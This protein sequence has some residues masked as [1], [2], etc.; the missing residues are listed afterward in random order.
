MIIATDVKYNDDGTAKA[1]AVGFHTWSDATPAGTW[2]AHLDEV[3]EYV[4]GQFYKRE[5]PCL[6]KVLSKIPHQIDTVIVDGHTWLTADK[7][8]LGH[9]LY[10]ALG[11]TTPVVGIAKRP[12][13]EGI[14]AEVYR[15]ESKNPLHVTADGMD[16][17]DAAG[18][19]RSM[20]G[21]FRQATLL[22]LTD[23][24]TRQE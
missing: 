7:P 21:K 11:S 20:H 9:Y 22:K 16:V 5:L 14:A 18:A 15:G 4:P 10:E 8:G 19:L 6:L 2:I 3:E 13:H 23:Q 12:F 17:T 1:V 24:I